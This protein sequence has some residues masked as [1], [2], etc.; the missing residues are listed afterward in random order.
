[1]RAAQEVGSGQK[2]PSGLG[3]VVAECLWHAVEHVEGHAFARVVAAFEALS[4]RW[5][6]LGFL[7]E[8]ARIARQ[9][10]RAWNEGWKDAP[11]TRALAVRVAYAVAVTT[12][13]HVTEREAHDDIARAQVISQFAGFP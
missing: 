6:S 5:V 12:V 13:A 11:E 3:N 1:M 8:F 9:A 2:L 4:D 10:K 7:R